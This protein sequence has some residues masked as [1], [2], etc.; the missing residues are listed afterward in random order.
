MSEYQYH[1]WQ[2]IDR[3]LTPQEQMDVDRLSSHIEVT[4][5]HALVTYHWSDFKHDPKQ[6]LLDYFDAYFYCANWGTL[7]LMFRFP[8]GLVDKEAVA[9]YCD[10][11]MI[12]F[13][14]R[15][16]YDVLDLNFYADGYYPGNGWM[17]AE[18]GLSGFIH[19]HD[20]L[21][22]GDY[23]LLYL[24]WLC[25]KTTR[26]SYG[27]ET[28]EEYIPTNSPEPEPPV[29]AGLND[30]S[31]SLQHFINVFDAN[32]YLVQAAAERSQNLSKSPEVNYREAVL[33]L[34]RLEC[35]DFLVNL[36]EGKPGT[37]AKLRKRL[38][39]FSPQQ[40]A[41]PYEKSRSVQQLEHRAYQIKKAE[42]I[43]LAE[44]AR[45]KHIAEME[46][47]ALRE[48]QAWAEVDAL[49]ANGRKLASVYEQATAQ[50]KKLNQ[51]A[52]FQQT[53]PE[54]KLRIQALAEKYAR[55][56]ALI[57]RWRREGWV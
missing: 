19:L 29:P 46:A 10:G 42:E 39:D 34:S 12:S 24:A 40:E 26:A 13:E 32:E 11:D 3:V 15:R 14:T 16:Q 35:D 20:D 18:N 43:R 8:T 51:L 47:L 9:P 4:A 36:L 2:T 50:L 44:E 48:E 17:E 23:R 1:E 41:E 28:E 21:I 27:H 53:Y 37:V 57:G 56:N 38:T 54:F 5:S 55:R 6:V 52:E 33:R 49:I 31:P 30:L 7:R 22:D 45:Q 25:A